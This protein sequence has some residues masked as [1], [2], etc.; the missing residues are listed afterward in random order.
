M[1]RTWPVGLALA[2][3]ASLLQVNFLFT[4]QEHIH[5]HVQPNEGGR[6]NLSAAMLELSTPTM[7]KLLLDMPW[8]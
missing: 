4:A 3:T 2:R 5:R 7:L 8:G 1:G 6:A